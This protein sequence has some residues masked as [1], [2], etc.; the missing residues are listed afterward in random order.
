MSNIFLV[1]IEIIN[2]NKA[3]RIINKL[4]CI[5]FDLSYYDKLLNKTI[6]KK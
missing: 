1:I 6:D 3:N 4:F 2:N 5:Y